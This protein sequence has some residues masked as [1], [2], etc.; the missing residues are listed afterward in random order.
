MMKLSKDQLS[1]NQS[2]ALAFIKLHGETLIE[3]IAVI[4]ENN[5]RAARAACQ[6]LYEKGFVLR[7]TKRMKVSW[8]GAEGSVK[9]AVYYPK[10]N[11]E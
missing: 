2:A 8:H 5:K 11:V 7:R 9:C 1:K 3:D 4:F 6:Q 10:E